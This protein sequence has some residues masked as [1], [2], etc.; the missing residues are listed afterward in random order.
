MRVNID[1]N[2]VNSLPTNRQHMLIIF[3]AL[4]PKKGERTSYTHM[5]RG[6]KRTGKAAK[7]YLQLQSNGLIEFLAKSFIHPHLP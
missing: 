7:V 3:E 1:Q 2:I 4:K 5:K 6:T